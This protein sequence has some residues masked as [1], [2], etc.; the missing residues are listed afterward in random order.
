MLIRIYSTSLSFSILDVIILCHMLPRKASDGNVPVVAYLKV[1]L[2]V[3]RDWRKSAGKIL[4][5]NY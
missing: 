5:L 2:E 4:R 3:F 1:Y